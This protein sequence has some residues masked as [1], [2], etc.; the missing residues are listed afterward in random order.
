MTKTSESKKTEHGIEPVD[1]PIL[2]P[3]G[4]D[5]VD[6]VHSHVKEIDSTIASGEGKPA[7]ITYYC[8]NRDCKKIIKKPQRIAKTLRFKCPECGQERVAFGGRESI[9]NYYRLKKDRDEAKKLTENI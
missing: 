2:T 9:Q 1:R 7:D 5:Y 6:I 4:A 3:E 8:R